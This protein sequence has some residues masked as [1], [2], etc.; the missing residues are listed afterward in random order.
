MKAYRDYCR[1]ALEKFPE[2]FK[3][4]VN[5]DGSLKPFLKM[6]DFGK[7]KIL[8]EVPKNELQKLKKDGWKPIIVKTNTEIKNSELNITGTE[9]KIKGHKLN[10]DILEMP[11]KINRK[12]YNRIW[13]H[14]S[15]ARQRIK[16]LKEKYGDVIPL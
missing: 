8:K 3:S 11:A 13:M 15:R 4:T 16:E 7:R 1:E 5:S 9:I 10:L 6:M 14:N 2:T 12:E